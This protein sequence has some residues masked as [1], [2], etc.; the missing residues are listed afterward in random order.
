MINFLKSLLQ[1]LYQSVKRFPLAIFFSTAVTVL[2]II[3]VDG[4]WYHMRDW[5]TRLVMVS[6]LG[7]PLTLCVTLILERLQPRV[8]IKLIFQALIFAVLALYFFFLLPELGTVEITRY[9]AISLALY[10]AFFFI[11]HLFKNT[12]FEMYVI[13][14]LGR[15]LVA[16]LYA[17]V[18][19]LGLAITLLTIDLL[20]RV[21]V[22]GEFFF[23][24]FLI[25]SGIFAPCFFLAG[26]PAPEQEEKN[27]PVLLKV[28]LLYIVM[29]LI[30][31]Y[32]T[33]LY[34]YFVQT[35]VTLEW[36]EGTV[37]H[38]VLWYAAFSAG[39]LCLIRPIWQENKFVKFF[40]VWFP[41]LVLPVILVMFAAIWVRIQAYGVTEN[42]Y[43]VVALGLWVF[44]V[45]VYYSLSK[46]SRLLNIV[47][48]VS[49]AVIALLAVSGPWSAYT[50]SK[51]SQNVRF[52]ALAANYDMVV[53]NALQGPDREIDDQDQRSFIS[54]LAYFAE[55]HSLD[56]IKL[57]PPDFDLNDMEDLFGFSYAGYHDYPVYP[58]RIGTFGIHTEVGAQ[59]IRNFNYYIDSDTLVRDAVII[60]DLTVSYDTKKQQLV[61][62]D[63]D[64]E[65]YNKSWT[66]HLVKVAEKFSDGNEVSLEDVTFVDE[67]ENIKVKIVFYAVYG[68]KHSSGDKPEIRRTRFYLLF[69]EKG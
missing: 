31:I 41:R 61:V 9:I 18:L 13:K 2:L 53:G 10:M 51:Y 21:A 67:K 24:L 62:M 69:N 28:L 11:P 26:L 56:D 16:V 23:Y 64:E 15:F 39:V 14:V 60:E 12:A 45:M 63:N 35:L 36:P 33:I 46:I 44:G 22:P 29:P 20:L 40:S 37:S 65:I 42:R 7:F 4:T 32:L 8:A 68:E 47:L 54:I 43:F 66:D 30:L 38:L 57:L 19:F 50:L 25:S 58:D 6:A 27:Y 1:S 17:A 49:L 59:D 3:K 48:P 55:N 34:I 52:E 5:L